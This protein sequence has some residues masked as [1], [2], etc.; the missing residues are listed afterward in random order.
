MGLEKY[1]DGAPEKTT[2]P[3]S[4]SST[5]RSSDSIVVER[6]NLPSRQPR[7]TSK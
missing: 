1:I 5:F 3:A 6:C 4:A 7:S 2:R